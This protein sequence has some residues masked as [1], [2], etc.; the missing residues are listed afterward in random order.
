VPFSVR[1]NRR[2]L[3]GPSSTP[4]PLITRT[5]VL[6]LIAT[7]VTRHERLLVCRSQKAH[8]CAFECPSRVSSCFLSVE[9]HPCLLM[10]SPHSQDADDLQNLP[11]RG[12]S[13]MAISRDRNTVPNSRPQQSEGD[14][15][16]PHHLGG[17]VLKLADSGADGMVVRARW[18]RRFVAALRRTLAALFAWGPASIGR[19]TARAFMAV[20]A[21]PRAAGHWSCCDGACRWIYPWRHPPRPL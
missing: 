14:R 10:R 9:Q 6:V 8:L 7:Q 17:L 4:H 13:L 2:R 19:A 15:P 5:A 16:E 20:L 12:E 11:P 3:S 21:Q 18:G 1:S